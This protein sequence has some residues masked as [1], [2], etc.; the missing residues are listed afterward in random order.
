MWRLCVQEEQSGCVSLC[1]HQ[2]SCFINDD[3]T[4]SAESLG[5]QRRSPYAIQSELGLLFVG[6]SA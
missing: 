5:L 2:M 3:V 1:V 6:M 4:Q